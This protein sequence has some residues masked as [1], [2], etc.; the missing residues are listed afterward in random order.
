MQTAGF[1]AE[2]LIVR[3]KIDLRYEGQMNEVSLDWESGRLS[4]AEVGAL[5]GAFERLYQQKF[6]AG[7]TH[8]KS[9]LELISFRA[10]AVKE[11]PKPV[12]A[13]VFSAA[14]E[15]KA[16]ALRPIA[17]RRVYQ[18]GR[19]WLEADI[20]DFDR[21]APGHAYRVP[22]SSNGKAPRSGCRREAPRCSTSTA[23]S[24]SSLKDRMHVR[25][26]RVARPLEE[27]IVDPIT[28]EVIKH[29][30]WQINDEKSRN[31]VLQESA[32][33]SCGML[34]DVQEVRT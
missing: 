17:R 34:F 19:G 18:H 20:Y 32:C 31:F 25:R 3:Y 11:I 1:A 28:F 26:Q 16:E 33:A 10:E 29:R 21:L 14:G 6:G 9:A 22:P 7:T 4:A 12:I 2:E 8:E 23:I 30:L 13:P 24:K 27:P 5:R 15:R